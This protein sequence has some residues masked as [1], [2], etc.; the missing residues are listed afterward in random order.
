MILITKKRTALSK[1]SSH[2]YA[3]KAKFPLSS[4]LVSE[5]SDNENAFEISCHEVRKKFIFEAEN[6]V[7]KREWINLIEKTIEAKDTPNP[8]TFSQTPITIQID[9]NPMEEKGRRKTRALESK[10]TE[11]FRKGETDAIAFL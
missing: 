7:I 6:D 5:I 9:L 2:N 4:T 8:E 1:R 11:A 3:L 10:E